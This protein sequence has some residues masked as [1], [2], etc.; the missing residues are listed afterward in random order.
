MF[1]NFIC[2]TRAQ[3][4]RQGAILFASVEM[5]LCRNGLWDVWNIKR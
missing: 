4:Y 3:S 2:C 1:Y 5:F